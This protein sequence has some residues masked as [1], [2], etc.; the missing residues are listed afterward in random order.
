MAKYVSLTG[1]DAAAYALKQARP[2]VASAYPITPQTELMHKF[3]EFVANGEVDTEVILV[4]SEHSAMSAAIGASAAG[5]RVF[6]ATSSQGLA[7]MWEMVYIAASCR[8][9]IVMPMVNRALSGP[10]N[11]HCDHSDSMGC[12][13]AGWI[14][15]FAENAQEVY[16]STLQAFRIAECKDA[17]LPT[18]ICFDG[19][20]ISHTN[21]P[22]AML[23]DA[24]A[25]A[26]VG[27]YK[28]DRA[29]LD[30]E[31]PFTIGGL[32]MPEWY[33]EHKRQ[34]VEAMRNSFSAI[35]SVGQEFGKLSGRPY[36]FL[37]GYRMDDAECAII[38]LGSTCGTARVAA[39]EARE[40]GVKA[41]VI[42][43]RVFRPFPARPLRL[44]LG[45][46]K[47]VGVLDRSISFGIEGGP[48]FHEVRSHLYG[49][50]R[51]ILPFVYG[52]GGRDIRVEQIVA[53][54][55]TLRDAG[56]SG[57]K[58]RDVEFIGLRE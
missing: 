33:F 15:L 14:Q 25:A 45:R 35:E 18:M 44:A 19:F 55:K 49:D 6:T 20:I 56:K 47:T 30:V 46:A 43:L 29:L 27:E 58:E 28:P 9:P 22:V 32:D 23:T 40:Q 12:R 36:G 13:D 51:A 39:D 2:D 1:N 31:H 34:Q 48:L 17:L 21:E 26:F 57:L 54:F 24:Q 3:A 8:L 42:K 50:D 11:I 16:D 53:V 4:E 52:L 41:G 7:L 10:I 37:D 38:A 5:A